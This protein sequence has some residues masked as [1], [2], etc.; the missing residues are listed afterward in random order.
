[1]AE[2]LNNVPIELLCVFV[3]GFKGDDKTFGTFP[4]RIQHILV[5]HGKAT[6]ECMIFPAYEASSSIRA[7]TE[8]FV[9]WLTTT[10]VHK[11]VAGGAGG[12]AGKTKVVLCGHSLLH[13]GRGIIACIAYDTPYYGLHPFVFKN[14]ASKAVG[15]VQTAHQIAAG[16]GALGSLGAGLGIGS[17]AKTDDTAKASTSTPSPSTSSSRAAN[18]NS[19]WGKWAPALIGLGGA[20]VAGAAAGTAYYKREDLSSSVVWAGDHL[21]YVG[22]LWDEKKLR[23]RVDSLIAVRKES[24]VLFHNF[25]TSLP[26]T[27]RNPNPRTFIILPRSTT[28]AFQYHTANINS[29][30]EDEIQAHT[31]MFEAPINDGF[32]DLGLKTVDII[33]RAMEEVEEVEKREAKANK[34]SDSR[35]GYDGSETKTEPLSPGADMLV[36]V[37]GPAL[38][39]EEKA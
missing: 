4:E 23:Y 5:S 38:D 7:A 20:V 15:Y 39:D 31:G 14:T 3:H 32:Y 22:N 16:L 13:C 33:L 36:A 26:T 25:Y 9:E 30:A 34:E 29:I 28:E 17:K 12:G 21:K 24:G 10:V 1:M 19:G 27:P 2:N 8:R 11:E 35:S 6:V 18:D 37:D